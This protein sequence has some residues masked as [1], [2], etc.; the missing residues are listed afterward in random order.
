MPGSPEIL[1]G[2]ATCF[3]YSR[4]YFSCN[5]R[6]DHNVIDTYLS[7]RYICYNCCGPVYIKRN[8]EALRVLR[9]ANHRTCLL[10]VE[11]WLYMSHFSRISWSLCNSRVRTM[12]AKNRGNSQLK[13]IY[14]GKQF[15]GNTNSL[16][17]CNSQ[18]QLLLIFD[19]F[20]C[21]VKYHRVTK[22][23]AK[24]LRTTSRTIP[25]RRPWRWE[26]LAHRIPFLKICWFEF[27]S[28]DWV[29][30][31]KCQMCQSYQG[32]AQE[33]HCV[34]VT[35]KSEKNVLTVIPFISLS[36]WKLRVWKS[37]G[38]GYAAVFFTTRIIENFFN[39]CWFSELKMKPPLNIALK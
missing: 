38:H 24:D 34:N 5:I 17:D 8:F 23:G 25:S 10:Q 27:M 37:T 30:K 7:L 26:H 35:I 1:L 16:T 21:W 29:K 14:Y 18:G 4:S 19:T 31:A 20:S 36:K 15:T 6:C 12:P 22:W 39:F 13:R 33:L 2:T 3:E 9:N 28:F 11:I 32:A